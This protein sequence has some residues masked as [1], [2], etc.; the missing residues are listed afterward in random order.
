MR[1]LTMDVKRLIQTTACVTALLLGPVA[2]VLA[3]EIQ[4]LLWDGSDVKVRVNGTASYKI[5]T[6]EDGQR[7][8]LVFPDSTMGPALGE[9]TGVGI[10]KG[11]YP[12][13]AENAT[14]VN[15]DLLLTEA[16][17][18]DIRKDADG[19]RVTAVTAGTPAAAA[20]PVAAPAPV[21]AAP[22]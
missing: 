18:L 1:K 3:A 4:S 14:A 6:L 8:R 17:R 5:E 22:V 21:V 9:L 7:L 12:Y 15:V 20:A 16:G 13:L 2:P 10:V 19:F 11:V